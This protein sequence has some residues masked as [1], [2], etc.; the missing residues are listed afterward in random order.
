M[1]SFIDSSPLQNSFLIFRPDILQT[2]I[3]QIRTTLPW[4]RPHYAIK[5]NPIGPIL[6]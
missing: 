6:E 2:Q 1:L 3:D 5:S 4:I